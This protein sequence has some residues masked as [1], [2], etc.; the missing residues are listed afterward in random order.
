M[1]STSMPMQYLLTLPSRMAAGFERLENRRR[2]QW[3]ATSDPQG[4]RLGSGGGTAHLLAEAWRATAGNTAFAGWLRQSRKLVVHG[5]GQS[6]CLPAYAPTGKM[7]MPAPAFRWSRGARLDQSLLDLQMAVYQRVLEHARPSTAVMVASGDVLLHFPGELP[8]FPEVDVLGLGMWLDPEVATHFGVYFLPRS[9]PAELGFF[10]Q[11]P[12]PSKIREL[13]DDHLCLVDTGMWLLSQRAVRVLMKRSGWMT[14][15]DDGFRGGAAHAYE[16]YGE[17]G[18]SLGRQPVAH[19][20]EVNALSCAVVPLPDAEFH[21]FGTYRSMIRSVSTLHNLELDET[22]LGAS[23]AKRHIDQHVLNSSF[24]PPLRRE[25]NHTLWI[26]NS[27]VPKSWRLA[28]D[29]VLTGVPD[30]NWS[31][32]LEPGVCLDFVPVGRREHCIRFHGMD[33]SFEGMIGSKTTTWFGRDA[34]SWFSRRGIPLNQAGISAQD[35]IQSALLFPVVRI[36]DLDARF[37]QWLYASNPEINEEFS[38]RWIRM[39]R[40]SAESILTDVNLSRLYRQ[41]ATNRAA[42]LQPMLKNARYSVFL[43]LDMEATAR[44]YAASGAPLP[45]SSLAAQDGPL[46]RMHEDVFRAAVMRLRKQQGWEQYEDRAFELLRQTIVHEAQLSPALPRL[47]IQEDQIVWARSPVR[48]DLAGGWTDTPPYCL[49][50][51]G[52]VLNL[53]VDL[54]GQPPIQVFGRLCENPEL[55]LRSIDLGVERRIHTYEELATFAHPNSEFA[56]AKAACALAGFLPAFH[57]QG[58][59][60]SLKQ[61]LKKFGG[62]IEISVLSAVPK[63]SGLGT[64]S[65]LAATLL[66]ALNDLCGLNWDRNVL[67]SRTMAMEQMITSGGGWQDQAGAIFRGIKLIESAPGLVQKPTLRWL[68]NHLFERDHANRSILLYYTGLTRLAKNILQEVVRG[69]FLNSASHLRIIEEIGA[70]AERAAG[71]IQRCDYDGLVASI[72]RSWQLNQQLDPGT[73]PPAV[74][75]IWK[76]IDAHVAGGK[77]LG[78]GGGGYLLLFAKD[79]TA[80]QHIRRILT[81]NPPNPKARFVDFSLSESGLQV[82]RS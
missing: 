30:N 44:M 66:A 46:P 50:R 14:R 34:M 32:D 27:I 19:D 28:C 4:A 57:A 62:G 75:C 49:Q 12:P 56:L 10:L 43:R 22:K 77:L 71:A 69:V 68:P 9:H 38:M 64:S 82:T 80:A 16:L 37:L 58:G 65:V 8:A 47:C 72:R 59:F 42:C 13:A 63:G 60:P 21:H 1:E 53:G 23:G 70:N 31:L 48:L 7:L 54:N 2:P 67:F 36:E 15:T 41:R 26:E 3:F 79:E 61:Q 25:E 78:A 35:D 45:K 18:L 11:K 81:D 17:F 52:K 73:N 51:G 40:C 33:D 39:P 55:V 6:R 74:Q 24:A 20:P 76:R 29:H 5:G